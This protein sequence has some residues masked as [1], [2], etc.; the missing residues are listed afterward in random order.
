MQVAPIC[1]PA[2]LPGPLLIAVL[3]LI[4]AWQVVALRKYN[5]GASRRMCACAILGWVVA[6]AAFVAPLCALSE[7]PLFARAAQ[8][9]ILILAAAPLI[10]IGLPRMRAATASLRLWTNAALFFTSLWLWYLPIPPGGTSA[11]TAVYWLMQ[12]TLFGSSI[13][14]WRE[15]LARPWRAV[16][17]TGRPA[18]IDG[19]ALQK[20]P[21]L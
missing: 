1:G 2:S 17:G 15:L 14:L 6:A 12:L 19:R 8:Q 4:C 3:G 20:L 18:A 11:S 9:M 10:A 7:S 21:H 5:Y 16:V 13:L